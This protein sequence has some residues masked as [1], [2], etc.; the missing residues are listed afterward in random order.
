MKKNLLFSYLLIATMS[1][2]FVS[3]S[4]SDKFV[5]AVTDL[6]QKGNGWNALRKLNLRTGEYSD[7]LLN[8]LNTKAIAYD[9]VSKKEIL[10]TAAD[11]KTGI[12]LQT[13]FTTGVAAIAFDSRN[14]RLFF[15]PMFIDQLRYI[16]LNTMKLYYVTDQ[17]FTSLG[18]MHN[19]EGKS[20]T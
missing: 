6:D 15:T 11:T 17:S 2:P 12:N 16:D 20:I 13:P 9:A 3:N 14:N 7:V 8:G 10:A 19:D 18:S 1:L 4:Q 5:Y